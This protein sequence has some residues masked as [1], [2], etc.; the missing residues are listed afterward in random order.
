MKSSKKS[1]VAVLMAFVFISVTMTSCDRHH[2]PTYSHAPAE[3][4]TNQAKA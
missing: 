2:C 4:V 3:K 1:L